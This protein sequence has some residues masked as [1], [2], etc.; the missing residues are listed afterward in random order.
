QIAEKAPSPY[1][2]ERHVHLRGEG[3]G[4][5]RKH[6]LDEV[7]AEVADAGE[8]EHVAS[9]LPF[10][11]NR[12][13]RREATGGHGVPQAGILRTLGEPQRHKDTKLRP[14]GRLWLLR[15]FVPWWWLV[16]GRPVGSFTIDRR[17][18]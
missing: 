11:Q 9:V 3:H 13:R 14:R 10:A 12:H 15:V 18:S 2:L 16:R 8:N 7:R 17:I 4:Q 1:F 6:Q 5:G